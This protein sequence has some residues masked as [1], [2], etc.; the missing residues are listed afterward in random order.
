VLFALFPVI[1]ILQL[2]VPSILYHNVAKLSPRAP[3]DLSWAELALFTFETDKQLQILQISGCR[4]LTVS[5]S[6]NLHQIIIKLKT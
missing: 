1:D 2:S 4:S 6:A 3:A 5:F